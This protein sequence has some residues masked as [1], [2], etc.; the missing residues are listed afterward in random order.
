MAVRE[1]AK[2]GPQHAARPRGH[3][4][5][6]R[7]FVLLGLLRALLFSPSFVSV[8]LVVPSARAPRACLLACVDVD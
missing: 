3:D 8:G 6:Q 2:P 5:T 4:G 1:K 7:R